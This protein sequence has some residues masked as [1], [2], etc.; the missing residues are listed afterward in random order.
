MLSIV[1]TSPVSV[2]TRLRVVTCPGEAAKTDNS[3]QRVVFHP[4]LG[5]GWA[6]RGHGQSRVARNHPR[7]RLVRLARDARL[8]PGR[9]LRARPA[10]RARR[11]LEGRLTT[12]DPA[13]A[14]LY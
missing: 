1:T 3:E 13:L 7:R 11:P 4:H 5:V 8:A 12:A 14:L 6:A 9:P 2:A 10:A